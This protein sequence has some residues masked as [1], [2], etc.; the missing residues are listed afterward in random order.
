MTM[1]SF[2]CYEPHAS[3]GDRFRVGGEA[4]TFEWRQHDYHDLNVPNLKGLNISWVV[5]SDARIFRRYEECQLNTGKAISSRVPNFREYWQD[6][7]GY[8]Q[9]YSSD[10]VQIAFAAPPMPGFEAFVM[11]IV[12]A[13][14]GVEVLTP[15]ITFAEKES[16]PSPSCRAFL[17]DYEPAFFGNY[18]NASDNYPI[19]RPY[20]S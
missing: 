19:F 15:S 13:G 10:A 9:R 3:F 1:F 11:S 16:A 6:A 20:R 7:K 8:M 14:M 12:A 4:D 2:K 18:E 5:E 17:E